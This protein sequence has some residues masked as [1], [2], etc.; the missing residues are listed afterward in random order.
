MS[1]RKFGNTRKL[2]SGRFQANYWHDGLR[3]TADRTFRSET[4]A[5]DWL[6]QHRA[7]ILK[8]TWIDPNGARETLSSYATEWLAGR[9]DLEVR[10]AELYAQL[11]TQHILPKLGHFT[12]R[13]LAESPNRVRAWRANLPA[14]IVAHE[15]RAADDGMR[16]QRSNVTGHTTAAKAYRL[17]SQIMRTALVDDLIV[18]SPCRV[19]GGGKESA[20]E[21]ETVTLSEAQILMDAM[22][23][24]L[25]AALLMAIWCQFRRA[26][27]LGLR[28]QDLDLK[29]GTVRVLKTRVLR[30]DGS[31]I[32]KDPKS[33]AG[34]R[35]LA[36]PSHILP[37]L[38]QHLELFV[39][40]APDAYVFTGVKGRPLSPTTLYKH[41]NR[42][43]LVIGRPALRPHDLRHTGLTLFAAMGATI[44]ELMH[45]GGHSSPNAALR[46][47]H[48]TSDRDRFLAD[49]LSTFAQPS[50][51]VTDT[52][53]STDPGSSPQPDDKGGDDDELT[54]KAAS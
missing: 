1:G 27:L 39:S 14:A 40:D 9:H 52:S 54:D 3:H 4:A 32:E 25:R 47:Q 12:L 36:I 10:T 33:E 51:G 35:V 49:A 50:P 29:A 13:E 34:R 46:Y 26:E 45:R 43:K 18:K 8:G 6:T 5:R 44:A 21:R 37:K 23:E 20:P 16:K 41:W 7:E 2:P 17:L 48:A 19:K 15:K 11:L 24:R 38:V 53:G 30:G 28:R 31:S 42:A 22:P